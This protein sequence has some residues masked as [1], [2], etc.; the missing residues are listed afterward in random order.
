MAVKRALSWSNGLV[1]IIINRHP[2]LVLDLRWLSADLS[3]NVDV[4]VDY[5]H[6]FSRSADQS[7]DV[8][9]FG[10]ERIFEHYYIPAFW[11]EELIDAL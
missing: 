10:L 2:Q 7:F 8:I 4:A 9:Y 11:F 3:V 6:R 1:V 5:F